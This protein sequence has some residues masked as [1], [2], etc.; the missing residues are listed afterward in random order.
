[1]LE[2][3]RHNHVSILV[4]EWGKPFT[5]DGFSGFM[6]DAIRA[7]GLPIDCQ[8][9]GLRKALGRRIAEA[10]A[11]TKQNMAVLGHKSLSEAE[12]YTKEADQIRLATAAMS[13]LEAQTENEVCP[14]RPFQFG[15]APKKS[16]D[17]K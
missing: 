13:L 3:A 8:P 16:G 14:N 17:T 9:H 2:K 12:R 11:S 10:G 15:Q 5:V 1:M 7:A 6:R 4:T